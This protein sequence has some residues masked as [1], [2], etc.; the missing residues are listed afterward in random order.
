VDRRVD[1]RGDAT[2][3]REGVTHTEHAGRAD[4]SAGDCRVQPALV[5]DVQLQTPRT[6]AADMAITRKERI[7]TTLARVAAPGTTTRPDASTAPL[8]ERPIRVQASRSFDSEGVTWHSE[9]ALNSAASR[10]CNSS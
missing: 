7:V 5:P 6:A 9:V 1:R 3:V 2:C 10:T 4:R 8:T